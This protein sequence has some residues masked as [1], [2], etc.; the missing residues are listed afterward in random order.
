ME[1]NRAD[2][3]REARYGL[4]IHYGLY[5]ILGRGEWAMNREGIPAGE[6][7]LL[8]DSFTAENFNA[9]DIVRR[10]K[11]WGMKYAVLTTKHHEGFCLYDSKLTDFTALKSPAGRDLAAEFVGACR[12]HG[13]KTGLYHSLN[14]WSVRP[15]AADALEN[16]DRDY[17]PFIEYV[18]GQFR[19]ILSGYGKI[20]IL[21]YD[22]WWPYNGK[23]WQGEKL[24]MMAR[25]LQPGILVNGRCGVKGDFSTPEGHLPSPAPR[26][27]WEACMTLNEHWGFHRGDN[28]WKSPKAVADMLK[29]CSQGQG[30]LLLNIGP[31]GDGSIPEESIEI[32]DRAGEWLQKNGEAV[33][34]TGRF[35]F[36]LK[37]RGD[38]RAD[39]THHGNFTASGK[40][41]YLHIKHWPGPELAIA[42]VK[43][44]VLEVRELSSGEKYPFRQQGERLLVP[45][46]PGNKDTSMPVVLAFSTEDRPMLYLCGGSREPGVTHC[47]YDPLPS[48]IISV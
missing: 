46:L 17:E 26:G 38:S 43:C 18:H 25:E 16:P 21:W 10:A 35:E 41:F 48:D 11:N 33:F 39:F 5:S 8:K 37:E 4:F 1:N 19:E 2:W 32:L 15:D 47:R 12:K 29:K 20:D 6:Y 44:K 36:S 7:A 27:P 28:D 9:D 42:G 24:N 3:F 45:G 13:L 22:G 40:N 34:N 14:D 31:R 23:G 30:N